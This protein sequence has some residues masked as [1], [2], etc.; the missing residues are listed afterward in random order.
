V[1]CMEAG[2]S[3]ALLLDLLN[4]GQAI[5]GR[6]RD[7]LGDSATA[8]AWML[9]HS[10]S[11]T[12]SEWMALIEAR[13][14]L[15]AVLRGERSP[16]ALERLLCAMTSRPEAA[17]AGPVGRP[18]RQGQDGVPDGAVRAIMAWNT[19]RR[20]HPVRLR[21]CANPQ[22]QLFVLDL[23]CALPADRDRGRAQVWSWRATR[24]NP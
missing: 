8:R 23:H 17:V 5:D 20:S 6:E 16:A 7:A 10:I 2:H 14:T 21:A 22:C 4:S 15:L 11:P 13:S 1:R 24:Q 3:E 9:E 19:L 18:H 12:Y